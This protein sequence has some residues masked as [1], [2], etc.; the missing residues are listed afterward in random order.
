MG[1]M[2]S[3]A[4][5]RGFPVYPGVCTL[6]ESFRAIMGVM[7]IKGARIRSF[8]LMSA[9]SSFQFASQHELFFAID[10][11][12]SVIMYMS[13]GDW[14][15]SNL[16]YDTQ[17]HDESVER[18]AN[19]QEYNP[20]KQVL[21]GNGIKTVEAD[22]GIYFHDGLV[23]H[24]GDRK[25]C[26][27]IT[28]KEGKRYIERKKYVP[29]RYII[30]AILQSMIYRCTRRSGRRYDAQNPSSAL[31]YQRPTSVLRPSTELERG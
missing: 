20:A 5:F 30:E 18:D 3:L 16:R 22:G 6:E 9:G 23:R 15:V 2:L 1:S 21:H 25:V 29:A 19:S 27:V 12:R 24:E 10:K 11:K 31:I 28:P 8:D 13:M 7:K 14:Y 4:H 26:K 17:K